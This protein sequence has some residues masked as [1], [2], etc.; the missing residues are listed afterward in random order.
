[1]STRYEVC[2]QTLLTNIAYAKLKEIPLVIELFDNRADVYTTITISDERKEIIKANFAGKYTL[3]DNMSYDEIMHAINSSHPRGETDFLNAYTMLNCITEIP[4]T[5]EIYFLSDGYNSNKLTEEQQAFLNGFKGRTTTMGIGSKSNYDDKLLSSMSKTGESVEGINA[6]IIQQELLAQMSDAASNM[7]AWENVQFTIL[8]KLDELKLGSMMK[9]TKIT[10]EEY[11][12]T[13]FVPNTDNPNLILSRGAKNDLMIQKKDEMASVEMKTEMLVFL[14]DRSGSMADSIDS[15]HDQHA[16]YVSAPP[17]LASH[18]GSIVGGGGSDPGTDETEENEP[19]YAKYEMTM[20]RMKSFQ[21]IIFSA[22][23]EF[24]GQI[25]WTDKDKNQMSMIFHDLTKYVAI[26][27]S[28]IDQ[29][30]NLA[31]L[32]GN[33]IN[34]A[35]IN[36]HAD[37]I[38]NFRQIKQYAN[39]NKQFIDDIMQKNILQ[40]FSLMELLFYNLKQGKNLFYSTLNASE[41]N[42]EELLD[43][44]SAGGGY[45]LLSAAATMS[46]T[47]GQTPSALCDEERGHSQN[48]DSILCSICYN[49]VKEYMFSCGHCFTCKK[50]AEGVLS[51]DPKNKCTYCKKDVTWIRQIIMTE[52]QK[53]TDHLY[54]CISDECFNIATN[55]S[56][57]EDEYHL[58]YCN[59]CIKTV[60]RDYKKARK[61]HNCFC[62]KEINAFVDNIYFT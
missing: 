53:N 28:I 31:N 34:I 42:I 60:K 41:Q 1:M 23:G 16:Y 26:T 4:A 18:L 43:N 39:K 51:S 44:V 54:K 50:C 48:R 7:D 32:I 10:K 8:G 45:K 56:K 5:T 55:V 19:I 40:D 46:A 3:Q 17:L 30:I 24:K 12:R 57:C 25:T 22:M 52:D 62:G 2:K 15:E 21:R 59:K 13:N 6:D 11:D 20:P 49:N 37:N 58:T 29:T 33:L 38:G 35:S 14:V 36:N 9:L 47:Q 61:I 27:D